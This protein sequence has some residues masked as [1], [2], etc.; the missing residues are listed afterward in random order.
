MKHLFINKK[1]LK[2]SKTNYTGY[3]NFPLIRLD[4]ISPHS[5]ATGL[6]NGGGRYFLISLIIDA[7]WRWTRSNV[8]L[9]CASAE[10]I[11]HIFIS[12]ERLTTH[13]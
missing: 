8:G 5:T 9:F 2:Y 7:V 3:N 10:G 1:L 11:K 4:I 6:E 13:Y 12:P